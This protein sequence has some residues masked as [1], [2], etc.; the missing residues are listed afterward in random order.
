MKMYMR[1]A[2][3]LLLASALFAG[4]LTYSQ[5]WADDDG[6]LAFDG[7]MDGQFM[8]GPGN[9]PST[10]TVRT[11]GLGDSTLGALSYAAFALHD[12]SDAPPNCGPYSSI[13]IGGHASLVFADGSLRL[14]R[15]IGDAC[16]NYPF[17]EVSETYRVVGG[18][19]IFKGAKGDVGA[20]LDGEVIDY[21]ISIDFYGMIKLDDDQDD[22]DD[23]D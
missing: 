5:T 23:F 17:I 7:T 11:I 2:S 21:T 13:G 19:G 8:T 12:M 20:E 16:F 3:P 22:D 1:I 15:D 14:E 6:W 18:T 10:F 9:A 4:V